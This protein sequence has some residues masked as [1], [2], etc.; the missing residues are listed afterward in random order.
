MSLFE[1]A[2]RRKWRFSSPKG[3][4][5]VE[6]LWDLPLQSA[7]GKPN[8]DDIAKGLYRQLKT[9]D[10]V[11]FV[12]EKKSSDPTV[13]GQFDLVRHII[14]HKKAEAQAESDRRTRAAQK[15]KILEIMEQKQ[16]ESLRGKSLEELQA[17]LAKL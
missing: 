11:S 5:S 10:D 4:L 14:G 13:Q 1:T 7:T 12:D 8:L 16:D 3:L 17:E 15:N 2:T 6:D 9:D